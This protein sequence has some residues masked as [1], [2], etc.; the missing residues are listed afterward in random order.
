M[1]DFVFLKCLDGEAVIKTE[2]ITRLTMEDSG[3][4]AM[5]RY[6]VHTRDAYYQV[7]E[8][9]YTSL[10]DYLVLGMDSE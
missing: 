10:R 7:T 6:Y 9:T 5:K 1:S 8:L 2:D 3:G 4:G